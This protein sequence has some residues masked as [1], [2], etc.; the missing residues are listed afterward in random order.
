M[1]SCKAGNIPRIARNGRAGL[2][3]F[4]VRTKGS[5]NQLC[6]ACRLREPRVEDDAD[7]LDGHASF[8]IMPRRRQQR[9]RGWTGELP[10]PVISSV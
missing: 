5:G 8:S 4:V 10:C 3:Q 1:A 7:F 6:D 2:P 9:R